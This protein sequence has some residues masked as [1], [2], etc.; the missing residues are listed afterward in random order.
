V[1]RLDAICAEEWGGAASCSGATNPRTSAAGVAPTRA[2]TRLSVCSP[3]R[4]EGAT[5]I[6]RTKHRRPST[7]ARL[8]QL[9]SPPPT[10]CPPPPTPTSLPSSPPPSP[11][12]PTEAPAPVPAPP[13]FFCIGDDRF[14]NFA[15]GCGVSALTP[16]SCVGIK[17]V[18]FR[19]CWF[20]KRDLPLS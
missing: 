17:G 2:R 12:P 8:L 11:P 14:A 18:G 5:E 10:P 19:F 1:V 16:E 9:P 6:P 4:S 20:C 3:R 7:M 15:G 13:Q